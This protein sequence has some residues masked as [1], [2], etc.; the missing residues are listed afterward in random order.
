MTNIRPGMGPRVAQVTPQAPVAPQKVVAQQPQAA[1]A[2]VQRHVVT[3]DDRHGA[4]A[5]AFDNPAAAQLRA[6]V[7]GNRQDAW[8]F[9]QNDGDKPMRTAP[10]SPAATAWQNPG[11]GVLANITAFPPTGKLDVGACYANLAAACVLGA[12]IL[13]GP[14][15]ASDLLVAV[16]KHDGAALL[17]PLRQ[18]LLDIARAIHEMNV[19]YHRLNRAQVLCSLAGNPTTA[20]K[21]AIQ[22]ASR[23]PMVTRLT[24]EHREQLKVYDR[25]LAQGKTLDDVQVGNLS[26]V[27]REAH[28]RDMPVVR[29]WDPAVAAPKLTRDLRIR[30]VEDMLPDPTLDE[31]ATLATLAGVLTAAA[32]PLPLPKPGTT[33]KHLQD[34]ITGMG[35]G[36]AAVLRL[37][38]SDREED[39]QSDH[40][41]VLGRRGDGVAYLYNPDPRRGDYTLMFGRAGKNQAPDFLA[42]LQSYAPRIR[43][44]VDGVLPTV[45]TLQ[46]PV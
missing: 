26:T 40:F 43:P 7:T 8:G 11:N 3:Q 2:Q 35:N 29:A 38:L 34:L 10:G 6:R 22:Q 23:A 27:L 36:A 45:T 25:F 46:I 33:Y 30:R 19:E 18:E 4:A 20:I 28:G 21:E 17:P 9:G 12:G 16:A 24:K 15:K 32:Q 31:V 39:T 41:V 44:D 13:A 14:G 5:R 1:P 42:A 37:H